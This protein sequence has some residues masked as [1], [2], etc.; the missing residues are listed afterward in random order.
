MIKN[1]SLYYKFGDRIITEPN[2]VESALTT[3]WGSLFLES[4]K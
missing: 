2:Y 1:K 4:A 3:N